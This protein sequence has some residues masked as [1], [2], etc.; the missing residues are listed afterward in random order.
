MLNGHERENHV[1]E[2]GETSAISY[3]RLVGR[4]LNNEHYEDLHL[5]VVAFSFSLFHGTPVRQVIVSDGHKGDERPDH[6]KRNELS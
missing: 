6:L 5:F 3:K 2:V 1:S 4:A